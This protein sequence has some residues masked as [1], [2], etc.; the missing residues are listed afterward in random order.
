MAHDE[1]NSGTRHGFS[2]A[3]FAVRNVDKKIEY[4]KEGFDKADYVRYNIQK[5]MLYKIYEE[6][7]KEMEQE[8]HEN[9]Y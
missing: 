2:M 3:L 5:D 7:K 1:F 6:I 4:P 8:V 9:D